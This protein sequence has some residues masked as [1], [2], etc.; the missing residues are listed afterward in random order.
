[1][2]A[3]TGEGYNNLN[4]IIIVN[5]TSNNFVEVNIF[6][7]NANIPYNQSATINM[8]SQY[9]ND[10][11]NDLVRCFSTP[12]ETGENWGKYHFQIRHFNETNTAK[13]IKECGF[14]I[15]QDPN[16]FTLNASITFTLDTEHRQTSVVILDPYTEEVTRVDADNW[17]VTIEFSQ[18]TSPTPPPPSVPTDIPSFTS[19]PTTRQKYNTTFTLRWN[20]VTG[21]TKYQVQYSSDNT[22]WIKLGETGVYTGTS[23]TDSCG[24]WWVEKQKVYYRL[25]AGNSVGWSN[26]WSSSITVYIGGTY[27]LIDGSSTYASG[28]DISWSS[29]WV[30]PRPTK[31]GYNFDGWYRNVN[32][33]NS[34]CDSWTA[35]QN[36]PDLVLYA[37]WSQNTYTITLNAQSGKITGSTSSTY[38]SS[39][40]VGSSYTFNK[41]V[42]PPDGKSFIGWSSTTNG[43]VQYRTSDSYTPTSSQTWY[44]VYKDDLTI[45]YDLPSFTLVDGSTAVTP[46]RGAVPT[47]Q[48]KTY[49]VAYTITAETPSLAGFNFKH[50]QDSNTGVTYGSGSVY[51]SNSGL[52]LTPIWGGKTYSIAYNQPSPGPKHT[53][54]SATVT[55]NTAF[56]LPNITPPGVSSDEWW[57]KDPFWEIKNGTNTILQNA[58]LT[59]PFIYSNNNTEI[60]PQWKQNTNWRKG[61]LWIYIGEE[62]E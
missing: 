36:E 6:D 61:W 39:V 12:T 46:T 10:V 40:A 21:A 13:V 23:C 35:T 38:S 55:Y 1:M 22:N 11:R 20:V 8:T 47:S 30:N 18:S 33:I 17:N 14:T 25:R 28:V 53:L 43:E 45:A 16:S 56:T 57:P 60:T 29:S 9:I 49:N 5:N 48:I 26:T 50:W 32:D 62:G 51:N 34:K 41:S 59:I 2:P 15:Y 19:Y 37:R 7:Y 24:P 44:A 3:P 58:G 54:T 31:P 27:K 4:S 52:S 42:T